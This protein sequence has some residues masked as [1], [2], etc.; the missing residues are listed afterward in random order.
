[1][2]LPLPLHS[3]A[4]FRTLATGRFLQEVSPAWLSAGGAVLC[5]IHHCVYVCVSKPPDFSLGFRSLGLSEG[6]D[7]AVFTLFSAQCPLPGIHQGRQPRSIDTEILS[8]YNVVAQ[9][10]QYQGCRGPRMWDPRPVPFL[11][12]WTAHPFLCWASALLGRVP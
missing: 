1:M 10:S 6:K 8:L 5:V 4:S 11:P 3:Y 12:G 2:P 7:C 9:K